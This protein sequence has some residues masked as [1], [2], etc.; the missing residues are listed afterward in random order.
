MW[1]WDTDIRD[2]NT[3]E[4]SKLPDIIWVSAAK[5][6]LGTIDFLYNFISVSL[7]IQLKLSC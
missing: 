7:L 3:V 1:K 6:Y 5:L 4:D 2:K